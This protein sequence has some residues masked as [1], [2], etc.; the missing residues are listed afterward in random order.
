VFLIAVPVMVLL[1]ALGPALLPEFRDPDAG[2]L[3]LA[4]AAL[5]LIAVLAVIYGLKELAQDGPGW[6]QG[7]SI[8][9][10]LGVGLAFVSRQRRLADPLLDLSLFANRAFSA[11]WPPTPSTS[12][13]PS[14]PC[15]SSPSTFRG[16]SGCRRCRPGCGSCRPRLG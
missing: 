7:L 4:S 9:A 12:S 11:A 8:A 5:S 16:C 3:D 15:S 10:G 6:G 2:R 13:S 1:L 14:A